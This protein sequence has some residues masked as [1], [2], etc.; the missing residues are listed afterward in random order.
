MYKSHDSLTLAHLQ[1]K[2][3]RHEAVKALISLYAKEDHIGSMQ[4]FTDRFKA[5]LVRMAV[6]EVDLSVRIACIHV[7][8][9]IDKHGLLEDAQRDEVATLVFESERR[10]R[11]AVAGFFEGLLDELVTERETELDAVTGVRG[12]ELKAQLALKCLAELLVRYGRALDGIEDG[13][14]DE[15][16][17]ELDPGAAEIVEEVKSHRG[18]VAFAVEA[19]WDQVDVLRD[20]QGIMDF[21]LLDHSATGADS[22]PKAKNKGRKGKGKAAAGAGDDDVDPACRLSEDEESLLVE[23]LVASLARATG[24][25]AVTKKVRTFPLVTC[26]FRN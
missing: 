7:L 25:S 15:D 4:H 18:R 2:D 16:R 19:L 26:K 6:G 23:V 11:Q 1:H 24:S 8:R 9:Q 14:D 20:W 12:I 13:H 10:V 17:D 5:Q 22:T 3:V 21:L